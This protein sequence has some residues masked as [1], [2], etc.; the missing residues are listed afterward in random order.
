M[1]VQCG[2]MVVNLV[3]LGGKPPYGP[4]QRYPISLGSQVRRSSKEFSKVLHST[5]RWPPS[6]GCR[7]LCCAVLIRTSGEIEGTMFG[8]R[9]ALIYFFGRFCLVKL[10]KI[11]YDLN[12]VDHLITGVYKSLSLCKPRLDRAGLQ[13]LR[14]SGILKSLKLCRST[15]T[16]VINR[17]PHE[18][19][20]WIMDNGDDNGPPCW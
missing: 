9:P 17:S 16:I 7:R 2:L 20:E 14:F 10:I 3:I 5:S 1:V 6:D 4:Y 11:V 12:L 18:E 19:L 15:M 8:S 13:F